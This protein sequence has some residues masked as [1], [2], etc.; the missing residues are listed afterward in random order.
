MRKAYQIDLQLEVHQDMSAHFSKYPTIWKLSKPDRNI[1]HRRVPNL[2]VYFQRHANHLPGSETE[3]ENFLPGDI[4]T[5]SV[6][7]NLLH[8]MIVSDRK[9]SDGTPLVIHNIGT[10]TKEENRLFTFPHTGHFRLKTKD[11]SDSD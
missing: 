4:I 9:S 3:T 1:D 11:G 5:C 8:I 10:G 6:P 2:M 7:P